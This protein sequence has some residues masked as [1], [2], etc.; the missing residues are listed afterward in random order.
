MFLFCTQ[1][2]Y[3]CVCICCLIFV[4]CSHIVC[5]LLGT[6]ENQLVGWCSL[7]L[8]KGVSIGRTMMLALELQWLAKRHISGRSNV[9][10]WRNQAHSLSGYWVTLIS[11]SFS[12]SVSH[13]KKFLKFHHYL[14]Q[15]CSYSWAWLSLTNYAR[16]MVQQIDVLGQSIAD[17]KTKACLGIY[18]ESKDGY[19]TCL[20]VLPLCTE[21]PFW[22]NCTR[23]L[24]WHYVQLI[25]DPPLVWS[26]T[27]IVE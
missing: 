13:W 8:N 2:T 22:L 7:P 15:R 17:K 1:C 11:Q 9:E 24:G 27:L 16:T 18:P 20:F 19:S 10:L 6:A 21:S 12:Q 26:M 23:I 3:V 25:V 5:Y 4:I 14:M